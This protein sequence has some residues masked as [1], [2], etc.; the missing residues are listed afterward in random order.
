MGNFAGD[1]KVSE[2]TLTWMLRLYPPF[3]FQRIWIRK[4]HKGFTGVDV[5][6]FFSILNRNSNKS[7]FGGT[8]FAATD[9]LYALLFGQGI[10]RTG[11]RPIVWLKSARIQYLKPARTS[12]YIS[13]QLRPEDLLD[14]ENELLQRGKFVRTMA[15]ELRD[16]YGEVCAIADNEVYIRNL[17]FD[18]SVDEPNTSG[19]STKS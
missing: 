9:P 17:D 1:M 7:I 4:F 12:L 19:K 16:K 5:K 15:I 14:A 18:F 13:L 10:R 2:R 3:L 11:I 8:I 6:I